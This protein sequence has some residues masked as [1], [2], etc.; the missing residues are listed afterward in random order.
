[1]CAY[2]I[3][4]KTKREEDIIKSVNVILARER[5]PMTLGEICHLLK[6]VS[7]AELQSIAF[8]NP[9]NFECFEDGQLF[10]KQIT[11]VGIC[12]LHTSKNK[13]C[14]GSIPFCTGLH[15]CK[16]YILSGQCPFGG[17]CTFGHDLTISHNMKILKENYLECVAGEDLKYLFSRAESRTSVTVPKICKFYNVDAGC[18]YS[19]SGKDCPNLHICKHYVLDKC[20]YGRSCRRSHNIISRDIKA[21]LEKHGISTRRTPKEILADLREAVMRAGSDGSSVGSSPLVRCFSDIN[22]SPSGD[23]YI[24]NSGDNEGSVMFQQQGRRGKIFLYL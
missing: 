9:S 11:R 12:E 24:S 17:Q 10:V 14:P 1:M 16:F 18:R 2:A 20:R 19:E 15:I 6:G 4:P 5:K 22:I 3:I 13:T 21:I 23:G 8:Q 7:P